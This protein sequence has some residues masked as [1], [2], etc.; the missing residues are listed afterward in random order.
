MVLGKVTRVTQRMGIALFVLS[1]SVGDLLTLYFDW[2]PVDTRYEHRLLWL[3][4][5][6]IFLS[7]SRQMLSFYVRLGH[8]RFLPYPL[9]FTSH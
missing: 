9:Q 5:S 3:G 1:N 8:P 2:C 4:Y 7:P 6:I